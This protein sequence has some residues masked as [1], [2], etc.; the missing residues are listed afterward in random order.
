MS[1]P[2]WSNKWGKD[3]ICSI[4]YTRLRPG[5][6]K[7]GIYYTTRLKCNH[8]FCTYPLLEWVKKCPNEDLTCPVCR[9]PFILTD[10]LKT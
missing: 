2:W 8:L 7:K 5:K 10:L 1:K 3:K 9:S 6:N 4:T